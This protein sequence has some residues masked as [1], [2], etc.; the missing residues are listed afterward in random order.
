MDR[1][2]AADAVAESLTMAAEKV[3]QRP[4]R[5]ASWAGH[6]P[7]HVHQDQMGH[8]WD[9]LFMAHHA[10]RCR[11]GGGD[12]LT[13]QPC[14]VPRD[15]RSTQ[16]EIATLKLM[17]G[18]GDQGEPVITILRPTWTDQAGSP[19]CECALSGFGSVNGC[20]GCGQRRWR[21]TLCLTTVHPGPRAAQAFSSLPSMPMGVAAVADRRAWPLAWRRQP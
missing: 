5:R 11:P 15:G 19:V 9:A 3:G 18:P 2:T 20:C 14:R 7:C 10:V 16:V 4:E 13:F 8:L 6:V 12:R 21:R 17:A 1:Y